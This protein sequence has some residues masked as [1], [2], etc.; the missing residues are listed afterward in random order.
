MIGFALALLVPLLFLSRKDTSYIGKTDAPF[1]VKD[2]D[3][4]SQNLEKG[5]VQNLIPPIKPEEPSKRRHNTRRNTS[6]RQSDNQRLILKYKAK[7]VILRPPDSDY[8]SGDSQANFKSGK[9]G[10]LPTGTNLVGQLLTAIDTRDKGQIVKVILPYGGTFQ[11]KR[12]LDR[13]T[14]LLGSI[15]HQSEEKKVFVTFDKGVTPKGLEFAIKAQALN[16]KDYSSGLL[17]DYHSQADLRLFGAVG[18]SMLSTASNVLTKRESLSASSPPTPKATMGNAALQ[19]LSKGF[20][21]EGRQT[22]S[23]NAETKGLCDH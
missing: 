16:S 6:I 11:H 21:M 3:N 12:I 15:R 8:N 9:E 19:G 18:L 22:S 2:K 17:G 23:G 7:Q 14:L 5:E 20:E 1:K 4:V 10:G 13:N